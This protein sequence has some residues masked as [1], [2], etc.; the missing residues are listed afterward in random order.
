M[1]T[2]KRKI[3]LDVIKEADNNSGNHHPVEFDLRAESEQL[4]DD[5]ASTTTSD[6]GI[7]R[8]AYG[9]GE[10]A[11]LEIIKAYAER[12]GLEVGFDGAGNLV[13]TLP[14]LNRTKSWLTCGSHLDSV[15]QGG[16]FDGVAG[17][18]AG[19]VSLAK[20]KV[21][22]FIPAQDIK[23]WAFRCEESAWFG[24]PYI[25]SSAL[26]GKLT[27]LDLDAYH[28]SGKSKL[29]D[30]MKRCGAD[31]ERIKKG[32]P[33]ISPESF[34]AYIEL[35]IEQ[36]PVLIDRGI[37]MAIVTGIR[38]AVR[39]RD[40]V[41]RGQAGH[42][43]TVPRGLRKDAFF[44]TAELISILDEHWRLFLEN[45]RDLVVTCGIVTTNIETHTMTRIPDEI[46]FSFEIRSQNVVDL[47]D[48]YQLMKV[49]CAKIENSRGVNFHFDRKLYTEPAQVSD[50]W[51]NRLKEKSELL[52]LPFETIA[53][54]AGHD[55]AVFA[56]FGIP[57]GMI[58][59]R[60]GNGSHN[61]G[62]YMD[63]NDFVKGT[64]LLYHTLK[65]P[66]KL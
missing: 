54:G 49:E 21:E 51:I 41:C 56:N 5:L 12:Y 17:I 37:P 40:V 61:P 55:A 15:P 11:A 43:G 10:Q 44:A 58:F 64:K 53:S 31:T 29:I 48:F 59:V 34:G 35:H 62:E 36:G 13:M 28:R 25:G 24:K 7:T 50:T 9:E 46:T 63:L 3:L 14:G 22:S 32:E 57:T 52:N 33:L 42:S 39:H 6:I 66:L 20:M 4:F 27:E 60:N 26:L 16:N 2:D 65:E 18:V 30:A 47:E 8:E 1:H 23:I 38:G 19:V 45:G